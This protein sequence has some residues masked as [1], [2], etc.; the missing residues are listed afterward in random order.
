MD[1]LQE[2]ALQRIDEPQTEIDYT[3]SLERF[4]FLPDLPVEILILILSYITTLEDLL[5]IRWSCKFLLNHLHQSVVRI[6]GH[7]MREIPSF[8][9]NWLG[10]FKELRSLKLR[11]TNLQHAQYREILT[12]A[13]L[14]KL[15]EFIWHL[16]AWYWGYKSKED[17][18]ANTQDSADD[19]LL[20]K[21]REDFTS[22]LLQFW[23]KAGKSLIDSNIEHG[24]F[25]LIRKHLLRSN[26]TFQLEKSLLTW[27]EIDLGKSDIN[28]I[29]KSNTLRGALIGDIDCWENDVGVGLIKIFSSNKLT[30]LG[31]HIAGNTREELS[32]FLASVEVPDD[33][34]LEVLALAVDIPYLRRVIENFPQAVVFTVFIYEISDINLCQFLNEIFKDHSNLQYLILDHDNNVRPR[35]EDRDYSLLLPENRTK[36]LLSGDMDYIVHRLNQKP[37]RKRILEL[38]E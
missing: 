15:M 18:P 10:Y 2:F 9:L 37:H 38:R 32:E 3:P 13:C 33:S 22:L 31:A 30:Y 7:F 6:E 27:I 36:I 5:H 20:N 17:L 29:Q 34:K 4:Q 35:I 21:V 19:Q 12:I 23:V 11:T 14:P 28:T 16:R 1:F 8:L 26:A 25:C 24:T